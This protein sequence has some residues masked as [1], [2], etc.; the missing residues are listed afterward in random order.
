MLNSSQEIALLNNFRVLK[1]SICKIKNQIRVCKTSMKRIRE[2]LN[3]QNDEKTLQIFISYKF[4]KMIL[5]SK[6]SSD[7]LRIHNH[8]KRKKKSQQMKTKKNL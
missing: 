4:E 3:R 1:T 2:I 6:T 7:N 5:C 8:E